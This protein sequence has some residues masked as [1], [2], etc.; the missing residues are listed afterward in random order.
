M[1]KKLKFQM[2]K[3]WDHHHDNADYS[4]PLTFIPEKKYLE[5][6]G[7]VLF[8]DDDLVVLAQGRSLEGK[9]MEYDCKMHLMKMAIIKRK[10]LRIE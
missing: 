7:W 2:I 8:E 1:T 3:V 10:P 4:D 6:V 5:Y 9:V